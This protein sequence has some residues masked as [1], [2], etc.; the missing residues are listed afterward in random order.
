MSV[1]FKSKGFPLL[2]I[3]SDNTWQNMM[4]V[5]SN[6]NSPIKDIIRNVTKILVTL[7]I[8]SLL[9][10]NLHFTHQTEAISINP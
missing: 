2:S 7:L 6:N 3:A 8:M 10:E 5:V 1:L 9:G 4:F